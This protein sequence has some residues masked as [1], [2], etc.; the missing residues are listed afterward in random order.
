MS[1]P[2]VDPA[3]TAE[4]V[5]A[6]PA[7]LKSRVDA[8]VDQARTWPCHTDG[9]TVTVHP[10]DKTTVTLT[11]P[12]V[13]AGDATCSCLLAPRCLHR[14]AVLSAAPILTEVGSHSGGGPPEVASSLSGAPVRAGSGD[15]RDAGSPA[16]TGTPES[17]PG[18]ADGEPATVGETARPLEC[19]SEGSARS[20]APGSAEAK[21]GS[22]AAAG[23]PV[24]AAQR[25]AAAGLWAVAADVLA[26]GVP[27][28]GA[29]AQAAL[30]RAV[31]SARA[32]GLHT[33]AAA[34][35]RVVEHLRA[36]RRDD[37]AF[38][39]GDLADD[40]RELLLTCH[41]LGRGEASAV[42]VA[43]RGYQP[44]GDLRL[45]GLFCEP[46]R[47]ATGH[48]GA[49]T[50]LADPRGRTWVVSD[51]KPAEPSV[52]LTATRG[53]VDL[54]EVRLSHRDLSRAGLRAI[55]AHASPA[56]RLSHGRA[57]QA[58]TAPGTGW[59]DEPLDALWRVSLAAQ[60]DRWLTAA[61]QPVHE[62]PAAHDLAFLEGVIL[63]ADR[64]GL[65]LAVQLPAPPDAQ[66]TRDA[67]AESSRV[68]DAPSSREGD[69]QPGRG[70]DAGA[71][72]DGDGGVG[73][74]AGGREITVVVGVPHEDPA[75][76]YV[77]NLRLLA[78]HAV[79]RSVRVAGRFSGA[80]RVEG[81][82]VA[83]EWLPDRYGGHVDL[84]AQRLTRADVPGSTGGERPVVA[85]RAGPPLHLVRHQLERVAAAGR[86]ALLSGAEQDAARLAVAHL[87]TAA[88]VVG[89]LAEAGVRRT[90]DVFGRL[91]PQDSR[92]LAQA[93]LAAAVYEQAA[94]A[95]ATRSAWT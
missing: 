86:A 27:G 34:A 61:A 7:R 28:G 81:L 45:F 6:L 60:V 47:A 21:R 36:A 79:G 91:D 42:G 90:R 68:V 62:R 5:A 37:P 82:A 64:R 14:A 30:L 92:H 23:V 33:A 73:A 20:G 72:H 10:D 52:A 58:V 40:L 26:G 31:H 67:D 13:S 63:G 59:F 38:Q 70:V 43:R 54:G 18:A 56:G 11:V 69:A 93:W 19:H 44:V 88:A 84:G 78:E 75:L 16:S 1:L 66:P 3:V 83:A 76:P 65:L 22:V 53:S 80:C 49:V 51:V 25:G 15:G 46:V 87:A 17:G 29:V 74:S 85:D 9:T 41:R 12:V 48:A 39:R 77:G 24:S 32:A 50:Y 57:R 71:G 94:S 2:P 4:A 89:A 35:V 55:N 8:A 95:E